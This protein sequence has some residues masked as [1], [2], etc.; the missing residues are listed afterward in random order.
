M[1]RG[2][3]AGWV[4]AC[5]IAG[6][7]PSAQAWAHS[8]GQ[9]GG[10]CSGCHNSG[11][12]EI[13][14]ST[15]PSMISPGST[16]TVTVQISS[17][18]GEEAGLFIDAN[19][20]E[21]NPLSGQGL[22]EVAAGLTHTSPKSLSGGTVSFDFQW[23]APSDP[24]AVRFEVWTL[25]ANGNGSSSGDMA[26][27][28]QFDF[29]FG[30]P[31][32]QYFRDFDADGYGRPTSPLVHCAAASPDG[33][34]IP[35]DDCDDNDADVY[36]GATEYCNLHDD[37]CNGEIDE[38]A[39][40]IA[41][42]PDADGDG[43]YGLAEYQSGDTVEGCVGGTPGYGGFS[44]DCAPQ[45]AEINPGAEEVCNLYDDNCDGRIDEDVRPLCGEG[46]CRREANTCEADSCYPGEPRAEECNLFDDDC[47]GVADNDVTCPDGQVCVA[48]I[49]TEDGGSAGS[50]GSGDDDDD[51]GGGAG[52][53]GDAGGTGSGSAT[54]GS[55][56]GSAGD[57]GG[58]CRAGGTAPAW[59]ALTG[60][61]L[62]SLRRR[63]RG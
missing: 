51:A 30:C 62:V 58:G 46:W 56:P 17:P 61:V 22:A 1:G 48:G 16:V 24:G 55:G 52:D 32:Q 4:V 34:V 11:D 10:G 9:P 60:F 57:G 8:A 47:D 31:P 6:A 21:M 39:L 3:S 20:G 7:F 18:S 27:E 15:S 63:L 44:G 2:R 28:G 45:I 42:Y 29:V 37:N 33:Y 36:P 43:Y 19:T 49:C 14:V 35:G 23:T 25:V 26:N 53:G 41:L 59:L 50:A 12:Y 40:P 5:G 54:E 38:D 13:A